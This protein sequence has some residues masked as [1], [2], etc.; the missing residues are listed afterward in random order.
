DEA[1][2]L[3]P[4]FFDAMANRVLLCRKLNRHGETVLWADRALRVREAPWLWYVKGEAHL[5][6]GESTLAMKAFDRSLALDPKSKGAKAGLRRAKAAR[7]KGD[8]Y[9][10][11][12]ECCGTHVAG[13]PGCEGCE[14]RGQCRLIAP[15]A[16]AR[17]RRSNTRTGPPCT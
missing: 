9:R 7:Q 12:Y 13:D 10:G 16:F 4:D 11:V 17:S 1:L 2:Q 14:L 8:V 5:G 15:G 6:L 3:D